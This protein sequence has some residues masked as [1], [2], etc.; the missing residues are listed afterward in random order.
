MPDDTRHAPIGPIACSGACRAEGIN[1]RTFLSA[2]T[3][4]AVAVLLDACTS[5]LGPYTGGGGGPLTVTVANFAALAN[6]GGIARVDGGNGAPTALV[7]TGASSFVALSMVCPHQGST[8]GINGSG[9][10]CPN[11]GARFAG[12]G[13][14]QGGQPTSNLQSYSTT[15]DSTAG[16]VAIARPA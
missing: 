14:W 2:T 3:L 12:T 13:A 15:Y 16:T 10:L 5:A 4:A 9:F 11:H 8:I 7:R 6:V 1:R